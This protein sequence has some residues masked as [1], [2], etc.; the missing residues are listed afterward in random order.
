VFGF[1]YLNF[2]AFSFAGGLLVGALEFDEVFE[3]FA[4]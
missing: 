3:A 4:I 2:C 1:E